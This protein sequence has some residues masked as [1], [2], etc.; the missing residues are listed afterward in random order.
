MLSPAFSGSASPLT[1]NDVKALINVGC[2]ALEFVTAYGVLG[3]MELK[4]N[5]LG[6]FFL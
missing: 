4:V 5:Q 6:N 2:E 3:A 1:E